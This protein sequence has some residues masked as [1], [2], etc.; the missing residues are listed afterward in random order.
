MPAILDAAATAI[1]GWA[2]AVV[3]LLLGALALAGSGLAVGI[4]QRFAPPRALAPAPSGPRVLAPWKRI[5]LVAFVVVALSAASLAVGPEPLSDVRWDLARTVFAFGAG[6]WLAIGLAWRAGPDGLL[7]MGLAC[8]GNGRAVALSLAI[9][10]LALP[11]IA[12]ASHLWLALLGAL[13]V[14]GEAQPIL[15]QFAGL[16]PEERLFP[17]V[18]GALVQPFF[19][20]V[21]FRGL[22]QPVLVRRIGAGLGIGL[23]SLLFGALHGLVACVPICALSIVLGVLVHRTGRLHAGWAAHALHNGIQFLVLFTLPELARRLS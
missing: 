18:L 12:C 4:L 9:Y 15:V 1:P 22:V 10:L 2:I 21:I 23:T 11:G 16:A 20:E 6:A 14:E 8:G 5:A 17:I 7:E 3:L 13:G 19:E